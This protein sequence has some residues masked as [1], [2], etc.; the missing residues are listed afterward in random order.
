MRLATWN[1]NS[2]RARHFRL[3]DWLDRAKPDV[4][5]LQ[6]TKMGDAE[7]DSLYADD[8]FR[9]GY[10]V[11]HFGQG[12]WNGVAVLSRVGLTDVV[13]GLPPDA[14]PLAQEARALGATCGDLRV[15][16]LY[17]PNGRSLDDPMYAYKLTWLAGLRQMLQG[18]LAT[19]AAMVVAGDFNI[20]PADGDVWDVAAFVGSTHVTDA[21][22]QVLTDLASDG[23]HDLVR[24]RWPTEVAYSYWDYRAGMFHKNLGMRID[25]V[26]GTGGLRDRLAAAYVDRQARKGKDPSDH[27]PVIVDLDEAR[28][29][30]IG[31]LV[32]PPSL[33]SGRRPPARRSA[34]QPSG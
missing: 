1:V 4:A 2:A 27:A 22:R 14:G 34:D 6:E 18:E 15:W 12:R 30:D 9:R 31:P 8:L 23:L 28:D 13:Q 24:H 26:L 5:C 21:E 3:V 33:Q 16:S 11:A 19:A 32:P 29:G 20:A 7:F 17:V 25:L 10:E